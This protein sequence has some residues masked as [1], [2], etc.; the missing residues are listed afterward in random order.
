MIF[1]L[2]QLVRFNIFCNFGAVKIIRLIL[3]LIVLLTCSTARAKSK[4]DSLVLNRVFS[5]QRNFDQAIDGFSSNVY[6]KHYFL[7]N[8][9]NASL[10]LIP[11]MY[12]IA[13]GERKFVCEQYERMHFYGLNDFESDRQVYYTTIPRN[14]RTMSVLDKFATP[15]LYNTTLYGDH[16]LSPFCRENRRYYKYS[17]V[18]MGNG[19]ARIHFRPRYVNNTQLVTGTGIVLIET[20]RI[21]E[22]E[23][24]GDYDNINFRTSITQGGIPPQSRSLL[25]KYCQTDIE[26]KFAGNHITS[27]FTSVYDCPIRL[28]DTVN[29]KG[30]RTLIDS[31]RPIS[32][33]SREQAVYDYYDSIHAP[34]P[35]L[36]TIPADT[37]PEEPKQRSFLSNIRFDRIG[38]QLISSHTI[39]SENY[40]LKASPFLEPQY[41]NF[42]RSKGLSYK[43]KFRGEYYFDQNSGIYLNPVLGYNFKLKRFYYTVPFRY[44]YDQERYNYAELVWTNGNRI[45]NSSILDELK[46]ETSYDPTELES[47]ELDL[48]DDNQIRFYSNN[49]LY[50]WLR[51]ELGVVYHRRSAVNPNSMRM[52]NKPTVYRSLAPAIG[53]QYTPWK[54]G[55]TFSF[56]YERG[57][58]GKRFELDY[59]RWEGDI[60]IKHHLPSMQMLNYRLGGGLY[61]RKMNNYFMDFANFCANNLPGGWDDDWSGDFQLLDSRLY[62]ESMYYISSNISYDSPL[63]VTSFIPV[64]GRYVERERFYWSG[65]LI[66]HSRPY[67]ELGYGFTTRFFSMGF[68]GSFHN[69]EFQRFGM[70]FTFELFSRW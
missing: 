60:S 8:K 19:Q 44:V 22:V 69:S 14:R 13:D 66:E 1:I 29:V 33:S 15:S 3:A 23:L 64:L 49:R 40:Y 20:G 36:D 27:S 32:L 5:Y 42:S 70:K 25:P 2:K 16:I 6:T 12:T 31:V 57:I 46:E 10:W 52:F 7:T 51:L 37:M 41:I 58:K 38:D 24:V 34:K 55:P 59:E 30:N 48:F 35:E 54:K 53:I 17:C 43:M 39:E 56:D 4:T 18:D 21:I 9:R 63:L 11:T 67:F 68:F 45:G 47:M 61:T 50:D 62:N 65:L 26:F 28:A